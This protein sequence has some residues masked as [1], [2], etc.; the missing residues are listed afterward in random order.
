[1][2][3]ASAAPSRTRGRCP[4][5]DAHTARPMPGAP[6]R[7]FAR[8]HHTAPGSGQLPA[9]GGGFGL[10]D[11]IQPEHRAGHRG[12]RRGHAGGVAQVSGARHVVD[13]GQ[14]GVHPDPSPR[15][16]VLRAH[17][18]QQVRPLH[19]VVRLRLPRPVPSRCRQMR[20]L[21]EQQRDQV[22]VLGREPD[23]CL[24]QGAQRGLGIPGAGERA[25]HV[26]RQPLDAPGHRRREQ[27][28]LALEVVVHARARDPGR[29]PDVLDGDAG[30]PLLGEHPYGR[31]QQRLA[32]RARRDPDRLL[33]AGDRRRFGG[34]CGD[35]RPAQFHEQPH[36]LRAGEFDP[37]EG[38][39][40]QYAQA[41]PREQLGLFGRQSRAGVPDQRGHRGGHRTD[42][43]TDLGPL[44]RRQQ[45]A[46]ALP[47]HAHLTMVEGDHDH[48]TR[49]GV[50]IFDRAAGQRV[51][52]RR[53]SVEHDL[54][55]QVLLAPEVPVQSRGPHT[56]RLGDVSHAHVRVPAAVEQLGRRGQD[57][58]APIAWPGPPGGR[59]EST[60]LACRSHHRVLPSGI[61]PGAIVSACRAAHRPCANRAAGAPEGPPPTRWAHML[62]RA[63]VPALTGSAAGVPGGPRCVRLLR[64]AT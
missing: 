30:I 15:R 44:R 2:A 41:A 25:R 52:H 58:R 38:R 10:P 6:D 32:S 51:T 18:A 42:L 20:H 22:A 34:R 53:D 50:R 47:Q 54:H 57:Q 31:G 48:R 43:A 37:M 5:A 39:T 36:V 46:L 13:R 16:A 12:R 49:H 8:I 64:W 56:H 23:V 11:R 62:D 9:R 17:G 24:Q 28:A 35:R 29:R 27:V 19:Q 45:P 55:E 3:R 21:G 40:E 63:A 4:R 59:H 26:H 61:R 1:M 14:R 7:A 60:D 33:R